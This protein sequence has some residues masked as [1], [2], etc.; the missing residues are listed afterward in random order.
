MLTKKYL[1][2]SDMSFRYDCST[3]WIFKTINITFAP[4]WT[5]IIGPNGSGKTT[6]LKLAAGTFRPNEGSIQ[7]NHETVF[8]EQ[9]MDGYSESIEMF[10][11]A[12][13]AFACKL[14]SRLDIQDEWIDR[15]ESLSFGERKRIQVAT[16]IWQQPQILA[17]DEPTNH[18]DIKSKQYL[19]KALTLYK[20]TGLLVTHDR[21]FLDNLCSSCVFVEPPSLSLFKGG[22]TRS[23]EQKKANEEQARNELK[24]ARSNYNK[25]KKEYSRRKH[26]ASLA[27]SKCSKRKIDKKDNDARGRMRLAVI[28]GKDGQA[29]K[30]QSQLKGRLNQYLE[31]LKHV[32]AKKIADL[33]IWIKGQSSSQ[34]TLLAIKSNQLTIGNT[35]TINHPELRLTS[36]SKVALTG[37]NGTGKSTLLLAIIKQLQLPADKLLFIPQEISI[38]ESKTI[39]SKT[40]KLPNKALGKVMSLVK[41]LGSDPTRLLETNIP[42]PGEQRKLLL[43]LGISRAPELIIMDEPTNHLDLDSIMCI[44]A[45]LSECPCA[46]LLVSHDHYFLKKLT[47]TR[48]HLEKHKHNTSILKKDYW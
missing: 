18:L 41:K 17:I 3:Q 27:D 37:N 28:T 23:I 40:R 25:L 19:F 48:W 32:K 14:K 7:N 1:S 5:G 45:A 46:L 26:E 35:L 20:G 10:M 29:G 30:R 16:A 38:N 12:Y 43:A 9:R 44:E 47:L 8:C 2:I 4:G 33:G 34:N 22:Y 11:F 31:K 21:D 24:I 36:N 42:S 15:W 6:L 39:I 13:D